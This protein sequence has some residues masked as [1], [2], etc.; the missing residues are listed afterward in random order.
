MGGMAGAW[1]V[2]PL[3]FKNPRT[4]AALRL[5]SEQTGTSMTDLAE[6]AIE[7]DIALLGADVERRLEEALTV[8]RSYRPSRDLDA[9]I[10][11]AQEGERSG[12]EP[13]RDVRAEHDAHSVPAP[14]ETLPQPATDRFG[15]L[16][17]FRR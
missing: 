1:D 13:L 14:L 16:V 2:F 12:L 4:R 11:A 15:V 9:Y 6:T 5:L 8:V 3:R 17:A 7:H 10:A